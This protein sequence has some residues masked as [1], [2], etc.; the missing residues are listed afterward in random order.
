M[1]AEEVIQNLNLENLENLPNPDAQETI[2]KNL[3]LPEL[4]APDT[5]LQSRILFM[6]YMIFMPVKAL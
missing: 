2:W 6:A 4:K 5:T 3:T 1:K